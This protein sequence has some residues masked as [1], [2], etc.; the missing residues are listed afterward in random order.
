MLWVILFLLPIPV[1][2]QTFPVDPG[3]GQIVYTEEVLVKDGPQTDL[4]NRAKVWFTRSGINKKALQVDDPANGVLIGKYYTVLSVT[5]GLQNQSFK[6]WYTVKLE[7]EDDRYWYRFS[8]FQLQKESASK[9][10]AVKKP[11]PKQPLEAWFLAKNAVDRKGSNRSLHKALAAAAH[12]SIAALI[13]DLKT[14][15][16]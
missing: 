13:K 7:L 9:A 14:Q 8:D 6:L 11:L 10:A 1:F 2:G 15:M 3:S 16:L 12:K 4:Y 5:D